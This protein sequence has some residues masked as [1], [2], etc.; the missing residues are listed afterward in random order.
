MQQFLELNNGRANADLRKD[1]H[2]PHH[3]ERDGHDSEVLLGQHARENADVDELQENLQQHIE[4]LPAERGAP[5]G[6]CALLRHQRAMLTAR[7]SRMTVI[8]T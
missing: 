6:C 4:A 2:H 7:R 8:R 5:G 1:F 3:D